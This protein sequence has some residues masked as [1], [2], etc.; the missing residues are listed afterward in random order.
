MAEARM[1]KI[2]TGGESEVVGSSG[3]RLDGIQC[4][5]RAI[6]LVEEHPSTTILHRKADIVKFHSYRVITSKTFNRD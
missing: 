2:D 4:I 3:C 1:L 6:T 5:V